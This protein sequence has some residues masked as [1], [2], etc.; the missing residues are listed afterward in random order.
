VEIT[1]AGEVAAAEFAALTSLHNVTVSEAPSG[2]TVLR[3][4]LSGSPDALVKAAASHEVTGLLAE[5]PDLEELFF[6]FYQPE[7]QS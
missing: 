6:T 2:G 4:L 7:G 5:E 3:A 1:F